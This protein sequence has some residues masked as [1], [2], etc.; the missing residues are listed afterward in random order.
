MVR[1]DRLTRA[2]RDMKGRVAEKVTHDFF[3]RHPQWKEQYGQ[4]GYEHGLRDAA[5]HV[6]FLAGA[7]EARDPEAFAEYARWAAGVL[8][9]RGIG[10][11]FLEEN[12]IQVRDAVL[13][14]LSGGPEPD[15]LREIADAGIAAVREEGP[16]SPVARPTLEPSDEPLEALQADSLDRVARAYLGA[17]LSGSRNAATGIMD[18]AMESGTSVPDLYIHVIQ[19][20]QHAL[21]DLWA[22]NRISVAQEHMASAVTQSVLAHLYPHLPDPAELRGPAVVTGV[23]GENHQIGAHMVADVLEAEGWSVRFL[24]S[25]VPHSAVVSTV[26]SEKPQLVGISVTMLFNLGAAAELIQAVRDAGAEWA[27]TILTGGRAFHLSANAW[28]EV[29]ADVWAPDLAAVRELASTLGPGVTGSG[30]PDGGPPA[31]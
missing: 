2:L 27:P 9:A 1:T 15:L 6:D 4:A 12:L 16:G 18:R 14:E 11:T 3:E 17:I 26:E 8:E 19:R 13:E 28:R 5:F 31:L 10:R 22:A 30:S 7:A 29:G 21:G 25:D 20:A 24:G 23:A